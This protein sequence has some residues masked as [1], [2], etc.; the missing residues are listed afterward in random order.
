MILAAGLA[1]AACPCE[2]FRVTTVAAGRSA[3]TRLALV[4]DFDGAFYQELTLGGQTWAGRFGFATEIAATAGFSDTW[5]GYGLGNLLLDARFL[6]DPA[7]K[8]ALG[9]RLRLP[10]GAIAHPDQPVT[11][12][13]TVPEATIET[14][15]LAIAYEG[16]AGRFTWAARLGGRGSGWYARGYTPEVIDA[17]A[18]LA[19]AQPLAGNWLMVGELEAMNAPSPVHLRALARYAQPGVGPRWTVDAGLAAPLL[20]IWADP[21]LQVIAQV[22]HS[23]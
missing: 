19:T 17:A 9:L 3:Y 5:H 2:G 13:G 23:F 16:S 7:R 4:E 21:T 18:A 6:V 11:W 12:W 8:H 22:R 14:T 1:L 10:A 20:T 15:G